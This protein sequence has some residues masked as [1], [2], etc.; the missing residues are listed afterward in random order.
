MPPDTSSHE[1][2]THHDTAT[3]LRLASDETTSRRPIAR[4][5]HVALVLAP[6]N[7]NCRANQV[8]SP[9]VDG[10]VT[11]KRHCSKS[12]KGCTQVIRRHHLMGASRE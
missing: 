7:Q 12:N 2:R 8:G 3:T 6:S 9:K 4:A 10:A 5:K 11:G 1:G